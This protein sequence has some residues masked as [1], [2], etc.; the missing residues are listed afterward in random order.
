MSA[1]I[2]ALGA[3]QMSRWGSPLQT[4]QMAVQE[5]A[6]AGM[7]VVKCSAFY[8]TAPIGI[9]VQPSYLNAVVCVN[10]Q[11][12]PNALLMHVKTI[13][14]QAGRKLRRHWGAGRPLDIDVIDIDGVRVGWPPGELQR[15]APLGIRRPRGT[16]ILPHPQLHLRS[17]VLYPLADVLPH[18]R[19]PFFGVG[20]RRMIARLPLSDRPSQNEAI[21]PLRSIE[22][23]T[24]VA[25]EMG[26][27]I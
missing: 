8:R 12:S 26:R 16:I 11:E 23:L 3:N 19:H 5:L 4:L 27:E 22:R 20:V 13:E 14:R 1:A 25:L 18:W 17:F 21:A 24:D 9:G 7:P 2:L 10:T 15:S 6:A